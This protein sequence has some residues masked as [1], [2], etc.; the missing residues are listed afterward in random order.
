MI[1]TLHTTVYSHWQ[2]FL[3]SSNRSL[4][5]YTAAVICSKTAISS[6]SSCNNRADGSIVA[7]QLRPERLQ[8]Q[9]IGAETGVSPAL[10]G[11][12]LRQVGSR[13]YWRFGSHAG[14]DLEV[15]RPGSSSGSQY[16]GFAHYSFQPYCQPQNGRPVRRGSLTL[17]F[18][19]AIGLLDALP[20]L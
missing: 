11:G 12:P 3:P 4:S 14:G 5:T 6:S 19:F 7:A 8:P 20:S 13:A 2:C 15:L 9:T 18:V 16:W 10:I 17:Q 1:H